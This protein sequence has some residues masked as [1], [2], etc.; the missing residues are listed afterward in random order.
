MMGNARRAK[1]KN[2]GAVERPGQSPG[3]VNA[4][5]CG[6]IG[7]HHHDSHHGFPTSVRTSS[8][9]RPMSRNM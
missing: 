4:T 1:T 9:V 6:A 3:A 2:P 7:S 8:R 5:W